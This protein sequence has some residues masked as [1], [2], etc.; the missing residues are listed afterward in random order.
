MVSVPLTLLKAS[1]EMLPV[2]LSGGIRPL[3]FS[4]TIPPSSQTAVR[5]LPVT[6]CPVLT[7]SFE[8]RGSK[9]L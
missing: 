2:L 9:L 8:A 1:S 3:W 4:L 5:H 7:L 6:H